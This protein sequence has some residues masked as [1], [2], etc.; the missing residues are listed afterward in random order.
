MANLE[1]EQPY[2]GDED[3]HHGYSPCVQVL[4]MILQVKKSVDSNN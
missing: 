4:G 1:G 3:D 2:L